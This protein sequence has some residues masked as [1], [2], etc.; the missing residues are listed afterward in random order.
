M[1]KYDIL[2]K[3]N[4]SKNKV[5]DLVPF[6][7]KFWKKE[8]KPYEI[9]TKKISLILLNKSETLSECLAAAFM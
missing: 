2:R 7:G 1:E 4:G 9:N 5:Q 3:F 8:K 6:E